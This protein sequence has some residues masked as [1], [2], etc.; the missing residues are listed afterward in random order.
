MGRPTK[1]SARLSALLMEL[2]QKEIAAMRAR[3]RDC[4]ATMHLPQDARRSCGGCKDVVCMRMREK[5]LNE[6]STALPYAH[7]PNCG[8]MTRSGRPCA[9]KVIPS[10]KRCKFH[11]GLSSGPKTQEGKPKIVAAQKARWDKWRDLRK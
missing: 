9:N 5:G 8:A 10:K 7:R 1:F 2:R 4:P 6:T 11:G 3:W